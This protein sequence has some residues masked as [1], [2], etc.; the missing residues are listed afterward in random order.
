MRI[1]SEYGESMSIFDDALPKGM[2]ERAYQTTY[3]IDDDAY[4]KKMWVATV[5]AYGFDSGDYEYAGE[6]MYDHLPSEDE[7]LAL[8]AKHKAMNSGYVQVEEVFVVD[9]RNEEG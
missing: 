7:L 8:L 5:C 6:R 4:L 1:I 3:M 9:Y 2:T